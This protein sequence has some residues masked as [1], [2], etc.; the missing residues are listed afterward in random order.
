MP[1]TI[2]ESYLDQKILEL[3]QQLA[4]QKKQAQKIPDDFQEFNNLIGNP[5]HPRTLQ[6]L[7]LMPYQIG[8]FEMVHS[9]KRGRKYHINKARQI[10]FTEL[11]LRIILFE[12]FH[13]YVGGKIIIVA[14]TREDTTK[15]IFLRLKQLTKNISNHI[16]ESGTISMRFKNGTEIVGLPA[17]PEAVTGLTKIKCVFMDEAAKWN[18]KND[19]PVMNA[20]MPIV[21]TNGSDLFLISTPK[22]PRGFFYEIDMSKE[23]DFIKKQYDIYSV[24]GLLYSKEE[25]D[26]MLKSSIED[27]NQEYL[28]Q[29]VASR[30][31]IFGNEFKTEDYEATW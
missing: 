13:K 18:L 20:F 5:R 2:R 12:C 16:L 28:N 17:N 14:G 1:T 4:Q 19:W 15:D 25:I 10:G 30:N 6:P 3:E 22:G 9:S 23:A 31:S 29:Y 11:A 27:P 21:R 26:E 7:K 24:Q 8:F